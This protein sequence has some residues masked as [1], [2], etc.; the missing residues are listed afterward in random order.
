MADTLVSG[1]QAHS[2][3]A[4]D[5]ALDAFAA[6]DREGELSPADLQLLAEAAWWAGRT[7]ESVDALERAYTGHERAGDHAAAAMVAVRLTEL[8]LR[9]LQ[10]A[11]ASGWL[12]RVER[13]LEGQPESEAH[14]WLAFMHAAEAV[15]FRADAEATV[16]HA[17]TAIELGERYA[18]PDVRVLAQAF[19]GSALLMLGRYDEGMALLDEASAVAMAGETQPDSACN[20][21]CHTISACRDLGDYRRAG[22]WTERAERFMHRQS[23]HGYPGI[24]RVHRAE[25]KRLRGQWPEAEREARQACDELER[26]RILDGVGLAH[27]EIGEVRLRRGDLEGAEEAFQ[28]AYEYGRPPQP[29]MALLLLARGE[30]QEAAHSIATSL[31]EAAESLEPALSVDPLIRGRLLPAQ[32]EIAVAAGDLVTARRAAAE[33]EDI[34]GRQESPIWAASALM[35][36]G[37]VLLADGRSEEAVPVLDRAWRR[38]R[39]LELPYDSA[40]SR[41]LLAEARLAAGQGTGARLELRSVR[42]AFARLGAAP[43]LER[44]DALLG[45]EVID[46]PTERRRVTRTLMFTD[47]VTSTDLV[48]VIGDDAWE[49]LLRWHDQELRAAVAEHGGEVVNHTGDGFFVAFESAADAVAC[50]VDIQRRLLAHRRRHGFAPWVRIGLHATEATRDDGDYRGRGVHAAARV[51]ALAG[52][53]EILVSADVL[54]A[55]GSLRYPVTERR[56]VSLKGITEEMEVA[57]V[58]WR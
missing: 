34:A 19:K 55:T 27:Y 43:D 3:R 30:T 56:R 42:S 58:D 26:Y 12:T 1:R 37:A 32:V 20:V 17:D 53:E 31:H 47:I 44:V 21:Y 4:W 18:S 36:R 22:E 39:D 23:I 45:D 24:C 29:G 8:A 33:L 38:F 11:V 2:R 13:L 54:E 57:S 7:E 35:C 49:S 52:K 46:T 16:R 28:R 25:L 48:G 40:R 6:A 50:A 14:A 15:I 10:P 51:G 41:L 9:A 5:E